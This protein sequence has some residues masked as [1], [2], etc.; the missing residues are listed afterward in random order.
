MALPL[1]KYGTGPTIL[2]FVRGP[3]DFRAYYASRAHDNVATGGLRERVVEHHDLMV[4]FAMEALRVDDDLAAWG[5]F[6]RWALDGGTFEFHPYGAGLDYWFRCVLE[7]QGWAIERRAPGVYGA[8]FVLRVVPDEK[9][10][11]SV[12]EVMLKFYG[13]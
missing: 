13:G 4:S 5:T 3:R 11:A 10:P 2:A 6:V 9:E 7:D 8:Q 1:I 12:A